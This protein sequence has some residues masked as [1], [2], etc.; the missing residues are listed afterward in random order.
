MVKLSVEKSL[1]SPSEPLTKD[2]IYF[3]RKD[4]GFDLYCSDSEGEIAHKL[5]Q[6]ETIVF[7]VSSPGLDLSLGTVLGL[8]SFPFSLSNL[9]LKADLDIAPT[10]SS[11]IVDVLINDTSILSPKIVFETNSKVS[12]QQHGLQQT[13]IN[14]GDKLSFSI[15]QIGAITKGR[16]LIITLAG[17]RV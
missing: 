13:S 11:A 17:T 14:V 12:S 1:L 2:T 6:K 7:I 10:G 8:N 3:V 9:S 5:N 15:E 16:H 4:Q